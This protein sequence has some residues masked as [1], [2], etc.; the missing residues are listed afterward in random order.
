M[1]L[2]KNYVLAAI[3]RLSYDKDRD[4]NTACTK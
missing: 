3:F 2:I 1:I 4:E